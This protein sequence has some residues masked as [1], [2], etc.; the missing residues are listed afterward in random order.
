MEQAQQARAPS[1][2]GGLDGD[3]EHQQ[4]GGVR[5]AEAKNDQQ[6]CQKGLDTEPNTV[7]VYGSGE[8]QQK[9]NGDRAQIGK[10]G[11]VA[12]APHAEEGFDGG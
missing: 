3:D 4:N 7:D 1:D 6:C 10:Q 9:A 11:E 8:H 2:P 12:E 5:T